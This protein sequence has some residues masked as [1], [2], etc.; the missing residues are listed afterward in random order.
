MCEIW[1]SNREQS[2]I[3]EVIFV[4]ILAIQCFILV[5]NI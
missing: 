5:N 1:W 3:F 2:K 4:V